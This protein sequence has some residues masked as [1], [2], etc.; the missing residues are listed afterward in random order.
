MTPKLAPSQLRLITDTSEFEFTTTDDIEP[1]LPCLGQQRAVEALRTGLSIPGPGFHILAL[2]AEGIG[3]TDCIFSVLSEFA[4]TDEATTDRLLLP[5]PAQ[6]GL[7][8]ELELPAGRGQLLIEGCAELIRTTSEKENEQRKRILSDL[9]SSFT[10]QLQLKDFLARLDE[11]SA[12]QIKTDKQQV[13]IRPLLRMLPQCIV[14]GQTDGI[15][16]QIDRSP[17]PASLLG[18]CTVDP[19]SGMTLVNAGSLL[20]ASGGCLLVDGRLLAENIAWWRN[21]RDV[22]RTGFISLGAI[23]AAYPT[24][25]TVPVALSGYLR[26]TA[27]VILLCDQFVLDRL[28]EIEPDME[29]IFPVIAE[30]DTRVERTPQSID[31]SARIMAAAIQQHGCLPFNRDA[32][33]SM[34]DISSKISGARDKL[35]LYRSGLS[36]L[37][38]EA[39]HLAQQNGNKVVAAGDVQTVIDQRKSR[40]SIAKHESIQAIINGETLV[41]LSGFITG[42]AN[43]LTVVGSGVQAYIEPAR[44]TAAV[45]AGEGAIIDIERETDLGGSIHSKGILILAGLLGSRYSPHE[46]LSLVASLVVE[47]NYSELDGDSASLAETL[48]LLSAIAGIPLKQSIAITGSIDQRGQIQCIGDVNMKIEGYFGLCRKAGLDG[49]HGVV[50][51]AGNINDLML[52]EEVVQ[53][54]EQNQFSIYTVAKLDQAIELLTDIPAGERDDQGDFPSGSFNHGVVAAVHQYAEEKK[55]QEHKE[56]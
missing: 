41:E 19:D 48:A 15:L 22:L 47:Q 6:H 45:R 18:S 37:L 14:H 38:R 2:G 46:P 43:G 13:D 36:N 32:M 30:F 33:A 25:I 26:L 10:D 51:P 5:N 39:S 24:Q 54:V 12:L 40:V 11:E 42:Q 55:Q 16:C 34:M 21:L 31:D 49:S 35:S 17:D 20:Q 23:P 9:T 56:D 3:R 29:R 50:V 4:P 7:V 28:Q 53:A 44:I 27:K 8:E 52:D 1:G